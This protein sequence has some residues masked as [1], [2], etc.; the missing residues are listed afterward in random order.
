MKIKLTRSQLEKLAACDDG[1]EALETLLGEGD[2]WET[3]WTRKRQ[4]ELLQ[5]TVGKYI[6][7]AHAN[8]LIPMWSMSGANLSGADLSRANLSWAIMPKNYLTEEAATP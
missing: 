2:E 3:D 6:G 8:G 4:I 5:T 7:W 1:I